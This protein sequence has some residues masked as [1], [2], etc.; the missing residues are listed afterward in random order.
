MGGDFLFCFITTI[1]EARYYIDNKAGNFF[2]NLFIFAPLL[3]CVVVLLLI[4]RK[5]QCI[6]A[7]LIYLIGGLL[8]WIYKLIYFICL[9]LS[10]DLQKKYVEIYT[11]SIYMVCFIINLLA[12]FFRV[13]SCYMIKNMYTDVCSLE[14]FIHEKEHAAFLQSLGTYNGGE[15]RNNDDEEINEDKLY[16]NNNNNPFITGR[17]KKDEDNEE[18]EICFQST[19]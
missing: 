19:L 14:E 5:K 10:E 15:D 18:E 8:I 6:A 3:I 16:T 4:K 9:V 11:D 17:R 2:L 12:I 7:G 13:G 1:I